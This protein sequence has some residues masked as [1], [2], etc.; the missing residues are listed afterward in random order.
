[1][2][3]IGDVVIFRILVVTLQFGAA[4]GGKLQQG[5]RTKAYTPPT[6]FGNQN[7]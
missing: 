4:A 6:L 1:M 5:R 2:L 7:F 3:N